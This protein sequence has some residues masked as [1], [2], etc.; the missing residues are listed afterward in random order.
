MTTT[1]SAPASPWLTLPQA[2]ERR[3]VSPGTIRR[4]IRQGIL[5]GYR[6][7]PQRIQIYRDDL[8]DLG[9]DDPDARRRRIRPDPDPRLAV[10]RDRLVELIAATEEQLGQYN[11][12]LFD[13]EDGH[14]AT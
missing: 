7:G 10:I 13:L 9:P 8:D 11:A 5:P 6:V 12:W 2:A 3:A 14:G 4:W 1:A